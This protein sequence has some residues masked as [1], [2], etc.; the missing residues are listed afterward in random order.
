MAARIK[1]ITSKF[2]KR[3]WSAKNNW[4]RIN[5]ESCPI[6]RP[7][8]I[9]LTG[10]AALSENDANGFCKRAENLL[11][12]LF[13]N[14]QNPDGHPTDFVDI[15]G[16]AYGSSVRLNIPD[17]DKA[18]EAE[19]FAKYPSWRDYAKEFPKRVM[20]PSTGSIKDGELDKMVEGMIIPLLKNESGQRL[21][22]DLACKNMSQIT[23]FSWC[24]GASEVANM[25]QRVYKRAC[26]LGY[27]EDEVMDILGA[28][29]HV[30]Y[31]PMTTANYCPSVRFDSLMDYFN[32][33]L[34][35][36][37]EGLQGIEVEREGINLNLQQFY[38]GLHVYSSKLT[39]GD[40]VDRNEHSVHFLDRD[41]DWKIKTPHNNA[42]A[43]SQMM[44]WALCRAVE[45]SLQNA[46]SDKYI[47]KMTLYDLMTELNL[48]RDGFDRNDLIQKEIIE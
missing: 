17:M 7:T 4:Q 36:D 24:H 5:V 31:S 21:T 2:G 41:R 28:C 29:M 19:F 42:D 39:N 44:A 20:Y 16:C 26:A 40:S 18:E 15:I 6:T 43:M 3:D 47:P 14:S 33:S 10:N 48:V 8:V 35:E 13:K 12:L 9:A 11:E 30:S 22:K 45:N 46:K 37:K 1:W 34:A 27:A 38:D 32:L 23:F 25:L